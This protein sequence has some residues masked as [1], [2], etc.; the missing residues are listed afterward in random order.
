MRTFRCYLIVRADQT[1]RTVKRLPD[2]ALDEVA[3]PI[4]IEIPDGWG[5]VLRS[6]PIRLALPA[7]LH[8]RSVAE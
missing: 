1:T 7:P 5:R 2:L 6:E 4:E 8:A 3:F